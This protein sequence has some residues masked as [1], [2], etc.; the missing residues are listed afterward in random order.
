M[1]M[2]SYMD[3][4][5]SE[6]RNME[7]EEEKEKTRILVDEDEAQR[8]SCIKQ[9]FE[10]YKTMYTGVEDFAYN[11]EDYPWGNSHWIT[12]DHRDY[13][14]KMNRMVKSRM[15]WFFERCTDQT[16]LRKWNRYQRKL[17][18]MDDGSFD[19]YFGVIYGYDMPSIQRRLEIIRV[20][21]QS[22]VAIPLSK[23]TIIK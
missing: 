8:E 3:D 21:C 23:F 5:I 15:D 13:L 7:D 16:F 1:M 11:F 9:E 19:R 2:D 17:W 14:F 18:K 4:D 12:R 10:A 20:V 6:L 22:T